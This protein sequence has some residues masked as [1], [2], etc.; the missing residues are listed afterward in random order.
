MY[1]IEIHPT[2]PQLRFVKKAV[3]VLNNDGLLLYPTESGYAIG[4]NAE[5]QKAINKLYALKKPMKKYVM[6]LL[7]KDMSKVSEY[8]KIDN[9][10]FKLIK[11]KIPG[12]YTFI[13]PAHTRIQRRL[14]V[15]RQE[16]GIRFSNN[17]FLKALFDEFEYP[18]LNTAARINDDEYFTDPDELIKLFNN[19]VDLALHCG[20]IPI[21]PTN[22][23][24]IIDHEVEVIRGEF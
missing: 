4:C 21:M 22:V 13:V 11:N 15:K 1:S 5:S 17:S 16:V 9:F 20:K 14:N 18:I 23:V 12:P 8:A 6:A 2:N 24:S 19:K 10:T 3:D 7:F